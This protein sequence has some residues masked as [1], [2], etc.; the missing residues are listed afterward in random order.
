MK[1]EEFWRAPPRNDPVV[2]RCAQPALEHR[3]GSRRITEFG[4]SSQ[5]MR[6][7]NEADLGHA[8]NSTD[9][10]QLSIIIGER[11]CPVT[12]HH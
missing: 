2:Q 1:Q 9:E 7:L 11:K 12:A 4:P 5:E 3:A 6:N 8:F 10:T